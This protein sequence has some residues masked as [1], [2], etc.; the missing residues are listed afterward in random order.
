MKKTLLKKGKRNH[1]HLN[2]VFSMPNYSPTANLKRKPFFHLPTKY[3]GYCR[4]GFVQHLE[5]LEGTDTCVLHYRSGRAFAV[6]FQKLDVIEQALM[7]IKSKYCIGVRKVVNPICVDK[8]I[9]LPEGFSFYKYILKVPEVNSVCVATFLAEDIVI[10]STLGELEECEADFPV[11]RIHYWL[12]K[13]NE[14]GLEIIKASNGGK[15]FR[16]I[17]PSAGK[18]FSFVRTVKMGGLAEEIATNFSIT[19]TSLDGTKILV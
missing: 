19:K 11:P 17:K 12:N 4:F 18:F 10:Q 8:A 15:Q 16:I 3:I 5:L 14:D 9:L 1:F 7:W 6:S 13:L 2:G